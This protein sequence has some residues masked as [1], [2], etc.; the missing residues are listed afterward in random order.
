MQ[1]LEDAALCVS[2]LALAAS[3]FALKFAI[4]AADRNPP[5]DQ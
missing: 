5:S 4:Q 3:L 2:L 1:A